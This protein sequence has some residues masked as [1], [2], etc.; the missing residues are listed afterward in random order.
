[1]YDQGVQDPLI[2]IQHFVQWAFSLANL[3]LKYF[4]A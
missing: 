4:V 3:F 2:Q 1:M